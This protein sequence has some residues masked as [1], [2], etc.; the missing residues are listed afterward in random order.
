MSRIRTIKPEFFR[1]ERLCTLPEVTHYGMAVGLL[2][3]A[4]DEGYFNANPGL[5]KG[6]IFP[7]REPSVSIIE[8]LAQL[9]SI[10]FI[11]MF[12][13]KDGRRYGRIVNFLEHQ[14]INRPSPSKI[15]KLVNKNEPSPINHGELTEDSLP[16]G[17]GKEQGNGR[18]GKGSLALDLHEPEGEILPGVDNAAWCAWVDYRK[19][20]RKPL[21]QVSMLAAQRELAAFGSEQMAVVEHSIANGYQGLYPKNKASGGGKTGVADMRQ[22]LMDKANANP[23]R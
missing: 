1:N 4:D 2:T 8:M 14:K 15:K 20:I 23:T 11:Q 12:D 10:D 18:E 22:R 19:Q 3:Y 17:K 5:I 13:G 6:E 21:K 9:E 7:L 16:E